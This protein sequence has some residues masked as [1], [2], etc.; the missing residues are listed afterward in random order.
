M[1]KVVFEKDGYLGIITINRPERLNCFDYATLVQLREVIGQIQMDKD[2]RAVMIT[3]SGEKAFSAG[4]DLKERRNLS[5]HEVR[6]NVRMIREVF[7]EIENL[8]PPTIAAINGYALGGGLELALVC[9]FRYV[10]ESAFIGLTEVSW[11]IIPGAGGTQRLARLI[12][13]SKAKELILTARR[14][15]AEK[16]LDMGIVNKVCAADELISEAV[17]LADEIMANG[18]LA[19][20]QA[21]YAINYGNNSDLNTGLAIEAKAYEVIIP[22]EDRVEALEAFKEKRK[23]SFKAR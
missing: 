5:E 2:I 6:R 14:I 4:A 18:P 17:Q 23:A 1:E 9:D 7:N 22:T 10:S 19:V 13:T 16:A 11:A 20:A 8:A 15:N 3:G 12:G 21:K